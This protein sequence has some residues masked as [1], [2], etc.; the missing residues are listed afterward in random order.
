MLSCRQYASGIKK[1]LQ[2]RMKGD[3][4]ISIGESGQGM[5]AD[6]R[7]PP[8]DESICILCGTCEKHNL[9]RILD[10]KKRPIDHDIREEDP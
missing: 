6:R 2:G 9:F 5:N 1:N 3:F 8:L 7:S 4:Y 10:R